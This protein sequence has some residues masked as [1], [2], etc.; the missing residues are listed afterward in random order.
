MASEL[1]NLP[2]EEL[3]VP[4][5]ILRSADDPAFAGLA[6]Y[7]E[8]YRGFLADADATGK[9]LIKEFKTSGGVDLKHVAWLKAYLDPDSPTCNKPWSA[10]T[11][12]GIPKTR[13]PALVRRY[14]PLIRKWFNELRYGELQVKQV[15]ERWFD[16]KEAPKIQTVKGKVNPDSLPSGT[17]VLA[18]TDDDTTLI[19]EME[20]A[21]QLKAAEL[22]SKH[23]G[24][25]TE[26]VQHSIDDLGEI[27]G[28]L[29]QAALSGK[30]GIPGPPGQGKGKEPDVGD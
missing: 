18:E 9:T 21:G 22:A 24:M 20:H 19:T 11:A 3:T 12:V 27:L 1:D 7:L 5:G 6:D 26:K 23:L 8:M 15:V 13:V 29:Y 14:E 30:S 25:M 10:A 17:K 16:A 28:T 2:D 4:P